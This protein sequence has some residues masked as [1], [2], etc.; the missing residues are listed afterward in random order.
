M[1]ADVVVQAMR[2][3]GLGHK[4][5]VGYDACKAVNSKIVAARSRTHRRDRPYSDLPSHGIAYDTGAGLVDPI[6][7]EEGFVEM[8]AHPQRRHQ[9]RLKA[10]FG[11]LGL[12]A[13]HHQHPGHRRGL[14]AGGGAVRRRCGHG[15]ARP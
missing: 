9:H 3:G 11:A 12:L 7:T 14:P 2:P 10:L 5:G 13:G 6:T 15:L 4:R 8:P 1:E